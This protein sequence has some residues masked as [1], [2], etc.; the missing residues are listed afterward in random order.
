MSAHL[1]DPGILG[2]KVGKYSCLDKTQERG[3]EKK[4]QEVRQLAAESREKAH[5]GG[6]GTRSTEGW[7][8]RLTHPQG[9]QR[10]PNPARKS[11]CF[12]NLAIRGLLSLQEG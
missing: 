12:W 4:M 10:P 8:R 11:S 1:Y 7:N 5:S 6:H 9:T 2:Y 3:E